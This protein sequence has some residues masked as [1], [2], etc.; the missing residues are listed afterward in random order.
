MNT[1]KKKR[2]IIPN[3]GSILRKRG[4]SICFGMQ[5]SH[6]SVYIQL[7]VPTALM[8]HFMASFKAFYSARLTRTSKTVAY[9]RLKKHTFHHQILFTVAGFLLTQSLKISARSVNFFLVKPHG[10][11]ARRYVIVFRPRIQLVPITT[12][13]LFSNPIG[14]ISQNPSRLVF[15]IIY[16]RGYS[17]QT[18][19]C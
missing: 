5:R 13:V 18:Y 4:F 2:P 3:L 12:D 17:F 1:G 11:K 6:Q 7:L 15:T 8:E 19:L 16:R 14:R 10:G 9:W